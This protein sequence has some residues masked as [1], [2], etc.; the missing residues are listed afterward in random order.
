MGRDDEQHRIGTG[1]AAGGGAAGG[2]GEHQNSPSS[3]FDEGKC[4][5]ITCKFARGKSARRTG[6]L[7]LGGGF[8]AGGPRAPCPSPRPG[9]PFRARCPARSARG[10]AGGTARGPFARSTALSS[11][12]QR[13][14]WLGDQSSR[15]ARAA[16]SFDQQ[17]L[18]VAELGR[19]DLAVEHRDPVGKVGQPLEVG[20][21]AAANP[22]RSRRRA[23]GRRRRRSR[24][25]AAA[26]R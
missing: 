19:L 3:Q 23:G 18:L 12:G 5:I 6:S 4:Y 17:P 20:R 11:V 8:E 25:C 16:A 14:P 9:R 1:L 22:A 2:I 10:G 26:G 15:S 13:A 21:G 7:A 24:A